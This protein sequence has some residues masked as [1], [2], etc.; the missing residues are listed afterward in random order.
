MTEETRQRNA[1]TID[2]LDA[3]PADTPEDDATLDPIDPAPETATL[4]IES[5]AEINKLSAALVRAQTGLGLVVKDGLNTH[6]NSKYMTLGALTKEVQPRLAQN[7][8]ASFG[9]PAREL[10]TGKPIYLLRLIHKSGQWIQS[11]IPLVIFEQKGVNAAQSV[12]S[13]VS[14]A[15]RALLSSAMGVATEDDDGNAADG[16][17]AESR[18][19]EPQP[20]RKSREARAERG[21]GIDRLGNEPKRGV[22]PDSPPKLDVRP[23]ELT[24]F[25]PSD[26]WASIAADWHTGRRISKPQQKRLYAAANQEGGWSGDQVKAVLIRHFGLSSSG[27]I[28]GDWKDRNLFPY[29]KLVETLTTYSPEPEGGR[30]EHEYQDAGQQ[31]L[32]AG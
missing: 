14:Y 5:S 2:E 22:N 23:F 6:L 29:N 4:G 9:S 27:E 16:Q 10:R 26:Q 17:P 13:A 12:N 1:A 19:D 25:I 3:P 21:G 30:D 8:I 15:R 20:Q 18:S 32:G 31:S 24:A 28:P 11:A 7:G